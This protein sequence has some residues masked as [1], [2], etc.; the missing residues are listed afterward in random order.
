MNPA[1]DESIPFAK[2][3]SSSSSPHDDNNDQAKR[4]S[5]EWKERGN[6]LYGKRAF[7]QA[8]QAYQA[9]IDTL[10]LS[11]TTAGGH[12]DND[13]DNEEDLSVALRSNLAIALIK[14]EEFDRAEQECTAILDAH[15]PTAKGKSA[16]AAS[17]A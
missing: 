9:G 13:N 2:D 6:A 14:L 5:L 7:E 4:M 1:E 3:Q 10:L 11:N 8:A 16:A 17:N 15:A 12:D